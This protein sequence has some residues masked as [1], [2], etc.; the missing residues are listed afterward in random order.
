M[1]LVQN[2]KRD[3]LDLGVIQKPLKYFSNGLFLL[4]KIQNIS[5]TTLHNEEQ[6]T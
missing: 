1:S 5:M 4:K 6:I 3:S 2:F